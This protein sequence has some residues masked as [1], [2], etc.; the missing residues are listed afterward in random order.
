MIYGIRI[1]PYLLIPSNTL[2][3]N[4]KLAVID[5]KLHELIKN[6]YGFVASWAVWAKAT[7]KPKSNM[8][9]MTILDPH[10]N[11][12]LYDELTT[13]VVMVGLNFSREVK[14]VAPFMNFHDKNPYANDFKIRYAF[15]GT[16][17]YGAY[18]TDAIKNFPMLS[19]K[20][21][22]R[23]LK[24]NPED[25]IS[26]IQAFKDELN[27]IKSKNPIILAF[28]SDTYEILKN[29]LSDNDY[30]HLVKLTHYSHQVGKEEYRNDVHN[31]I[32]ENTG[33]ILSKKDFI[34]RINNETNEYI[35]ALS[36]IKTVKNTSESEAL[37]SLRKTIKN[38]E[39]TII[40]L[41]NA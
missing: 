14:A 36:T 23:H 7:G 28:G 24:K 10:I 38:L 9:D 17:F 11:T 16:Q 35:K 5:H 6:K 8:S 18:M 37:M 39:S 33:I 22:I 34:N 3:G 4:K 12:S 40:K 15:E 29:G 26:N 1:V 31:Q 21:V 27:F 41:Q 25:L 32:Y 20:D 13:D 19:S 2:L 30:K